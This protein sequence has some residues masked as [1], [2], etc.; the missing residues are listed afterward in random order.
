M[1][2]FSLIIDGNYLLYSTLSVMQIFSPKNKMFLKSNS[3]EDNRKDTNSL[4]E[5][6]T[7]VYCKD[8]RNLSAVI[9]DVIIPVDDSNSWR[10]H[11][12]IENDY[13]GINKDL[14]YKGN[15]SKDDTLNFNKIFE[16]F[17]D[18]ILGLR[19]SSGVKSTSISG[20]E[21]DDII[22]VL[23]SL[24]N[25]KGKSV[26]I[27]SGDGD[28]T[29]CV[30]FNKSTE[31]FTLQY[32][33]QNKK[34]WIDRTTG[35]FLK[36]NKNSYSVDCIRS[37][38]NNT[39][40]T[41][42]VCNPYEVVLD[43]VLGGDVSDNI[44]SVII[45]QKQYASGNKKGQ[46]YESKITP[47]VI[48]KI[49]EEIEFSEYNIEDLFRSDFTKKLASSSIRNFKS[50]NK[51]NIDDIQNNI[52]L[53]IILVLLHKETIPNALYDDILA[54]SEN[55]IQKKKSN[56]NKQF[57]KTNLLPEMSLYDVKLQDSASSASIFK[58]LG[59]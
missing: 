8:I 44:N 34:M 29:Q 26:I 47:K 21:A 50:Q 54:W 5:K 7:Q 52:N 15:R 1:I 55:I 20:C 2:K 6:L 23:T 51:Y 19:K 24:L 35:L 56:I 28:L 14:K 22:F 49:K 32:Q 36:E 30:G 17:N 4:L 3:D 11:L 13:K 9:D 33:K 10:K 27:Y 12:Y 41:L 40:S 42:T 45:E 31:S 59:L 57:N 38:V 58:E 43:K 16:V 25:S 18:F 46:F 48:S 53:N 39:S 37:I